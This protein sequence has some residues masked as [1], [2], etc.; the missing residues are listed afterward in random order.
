MGHLRVFF[1]TRKN[2]REDTWGRE[3]SGLGRSVASYIVLREGSR[4]TSMPLAIVGA[5]HFKEVGRRKRAFG[6]GMGGV[7]FGTIFRR[8]VWFLAVLSAHVLCSSSAISTFFFCL[9]LAVLLNVHAWLRRRHKIFVTK[10]GEEEDGEG[11][12]EEDEDQGEEEEA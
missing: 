7:R 5:V 2:R 11:E 4:D 8:S 1:C 6:A 3:K 9:F 12:M 10:E